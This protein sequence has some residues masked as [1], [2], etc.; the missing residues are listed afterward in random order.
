MRLVKLKITMWMFLLGLEPRLCQPGEQEDLRLQPMQGYLHC[1]LGSAT[2]CC[3]FVW[4][5][6]V[7]LSWDLQTQD[8]RR[9]ESLLI[10]G[11]LVDH[12]PMQLPALPIMET[13]THSCNPQRKQGLL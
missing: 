5:F 13:G 4:V 2:S 3:E 1:Y 8:E 11:K 6:A 10:T 12:T 7:C 9:G